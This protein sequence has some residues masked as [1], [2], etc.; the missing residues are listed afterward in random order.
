MPVATGSVTAAKTSGIVWVSR[1]TA[2]VDIV[3]RV[4]NLSVTQL[5]EP[6]SEWLEFLAPFAQS[7]PKITRLVHF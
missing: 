1:W 4:S 2:R 3:V 5:G 6:L 7:Y